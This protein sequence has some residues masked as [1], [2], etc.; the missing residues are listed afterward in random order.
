MIILAWQIKTDNENIAIVTEESRVKNDN[1]T[2]KKIPTICELLCIRTMS[3]PDLI[4]LR[5]IEIDFNESRN[6]CK[7]Q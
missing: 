3:L 6:S 5:G 4:R 1:K 2:F 7:Q